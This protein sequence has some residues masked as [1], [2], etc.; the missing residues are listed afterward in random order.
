M[1]GAEI[2]GELLRAYVPLTQ[3]VPSANIKGGRL[4]EGIPLPALLVRTVSSNERQPLTNG[5]KVRRWARVS[6]TVRAASYADQ[7]DILELVRKPL[8]GWT[9][10][11]GTA[12][13]IAIAVA[14]E[15][16]DLLGPGDSFEQAQDF[17]VTWDAMT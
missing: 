6:V 8:R 7:I 3:R 9:G 10:H 4:P 13:D 1:T 12:T 11:L 5:A 17:R 16:P 14:G 2:V 15:G